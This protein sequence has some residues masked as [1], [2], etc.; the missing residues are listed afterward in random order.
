MIKKSILIFSILLIISP[1]YATDFELMPSIGFNLTQQ[2]IK[3]EVGGERNP[4]LFNYSAINLNLD[5][6]YNLNEYLAVG[7]YSRFDYGNRQGSTVINQ[8]NLQV[9]EDKNYDYT[10]Y[11]LGPK[12]R[13]S[14]KN[15]FAAVGYGILVGRDDG[16]LEVNNEAEESTPLNGSSLAWV[17]DLGGKF[18]IAE[19]LNIIIMV[20]YRVRYYDTIN[21][22]ALQ[23]G[24]EIGTQDIV[25]LIGI[26]YLFDL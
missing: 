5:V 6:L 22:A 11:W 10:E 21:D 3:E 26:S 13:G 19:N 2:Q 16:Y 1:G 20:E 15:L 25:P 4:K 7:L 23:G 9:R 8:N 18:N 24:N 17:V 14:Y 12:V